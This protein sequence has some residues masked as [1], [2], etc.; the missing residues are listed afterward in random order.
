MKR[1]L[2]EDREAKLVKEKMQSR[3]GFHQQHSARR[4]GSAHN[5]QKQRHLAVRPFFSPHDL[6]GQVHYDRAVQGNSSQG[7]ISRSRYVALGTTRES[8]KFSLFHFTFIFAFLRVAGQE[9]VTT[10]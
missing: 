9:A 8:Q 7:S 5:E 1:A 4:P 6:Q 10:V 2:S 3:S